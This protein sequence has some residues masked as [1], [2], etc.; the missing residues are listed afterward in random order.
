[1]ENSIIIIII[2]IVIPKKNLNLHV[3]PSVF[4]E[5]WLLQNCDL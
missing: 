2:I 4:I 5:R 3:P 1:M